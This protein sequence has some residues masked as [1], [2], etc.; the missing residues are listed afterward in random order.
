MPSPG[1]FSVGIRGDR[2]A[3][4]SRRPSAARVHARTPSDS[5]RRGRA[6]GSAPNR[7]RERPGVCTYFDLTEN[8]VHSVCD[9][10]LCTPRAPN[11]PTSRPI[12]TGSWSCRR[13]PTGMSHLRLLAEPDRAAV[14]RAPLLLPRQHRPPHHE[15]QVPLIGDYI[16]GAISTTTAPGLR[17]LIHRQLAR[18]AISPR[19][20]QHGKMLPDDPLVRARP[21]D[22]CPAH[23]PTCTRVPTSRRSRR[24]PGRTPPPLSPGTA[25]ERA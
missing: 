15:T 18:K 11:I 10:V 9:R 19:H 2:R 22:G 21:P 12:E 16:T 25:S 23:V 5:C 13:S 6:A 1:S 4:P 24:D 14:Q 17:H 20:H 8:P 7:L 3:S